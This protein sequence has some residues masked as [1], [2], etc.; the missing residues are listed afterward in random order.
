MLW[1]DK[2]H[3]AVLKAVKELTSEFPKIQYII[4]G[5][6]PEK[7]HLQKL[8][9]K[10][11]L[12]SNVFFTGLVND[13]KKKYLFEHVDLMVMPTL[14]ER[15]KRSIEGF[16]I[17]YLEAAFLGIPSIASDVGGTKEAVLHNKTGIII[18][19]IDDIYQSIHSLLINPNQRTQLG[20]S[21]QKR[22]LEDFNWDIV[23]KKYLDA[24]NN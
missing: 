3:K 24:I 17:A 6:G 13:S 12:K 21:A 5:E 20:K 15:E 10:Y 18:N 2:G 23:T 9:K 7:S 4:T 16:G 8:I 14:D 19:N 11:S 22:A 1:V